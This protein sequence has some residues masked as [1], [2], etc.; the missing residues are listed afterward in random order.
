M[1]SSPMT[2]AKA[3]AAIIGEATACSISARNSGGER[4]SRCIN[5]Q[6]VPIKTGTTKD[7]HAVAASTR[8]GLRTWPRNAAVSTRR[9]ARHSKAKIASVTNGL[10]NASTGGIAMAMNTTAAI[11]REPWRPSQASAADMALRTGMVG[12]FVAQAAAHRAG[13]DAAET[14]AAAP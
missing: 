6:A 3:G 10:N 5:R 12:I 1:A 9:N 2:A 8:P 7:V 13:V 11:A 4:V 14:I